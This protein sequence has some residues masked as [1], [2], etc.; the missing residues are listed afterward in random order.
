MRTRSFVRASLYAGLSKLTPIRIVG[1][2][3]RLPDGQLLFSTAEQHPLQPERTAVILAD[4]NAGTDNSPLRVLVVEVRSST[5]FVGRVI[6]GC[7][8]VEAGG[9]GGSLSVRVLSDASVE[10]QVKCRPIFDER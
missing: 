4:P 5:T 1:P 2:P 10:T 8:V 6:A 9:S 3:E 7:G